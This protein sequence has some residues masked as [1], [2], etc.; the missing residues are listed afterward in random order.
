[1]TGSGTTAAAAAPQP[2]RTPPGTVEE[3]WAEVVGQPDLVAALQAAATSPVHAYLL[4]GPEGSGKRAAADAFAAELLSRDLDGDD[5]SRAV[6]LVAAGAHPSVVSVEREGAAISAEQ[7][8]DV[9]RRAALSPP[10]GEL[11]VV[12]LEEFHLVRDAAP[13]L[14]KS[15]EEPPPTTVFVVLAEEVPDE[16]VTIASRCVQLRSTAVPTTAIQV[17]L[18][19]EGADPEAA[20]IVAAAS[21]GNLRR[22]RLLLADPELSVRR[23]AWYRAPAQLDGTGATACRVA[24]DLFGGVESVLAPLAEWHESE[25]EAFDEVSERTGVARRGDRSRLEARHRREARRIR[26]E[27]LRSGLATLVGRY[28]DDVLAGQSGA[29]ERFEQAAAAV[30][31]VA[32]AVQFNPNESLQLRALLVRLPVVDGS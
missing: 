1:M 31:Q 10:E 7:A 6:R 15:I 4:V 9:V 27:E 25:L 3:L 30:Q 14:L 29:A 12:V 13:I 23:D 24:D 8:R 26:T 18:V 22:A 16:L 32:D 20:R 21:G 17:R 19:E 2:A 28:R 5:R 11:Q